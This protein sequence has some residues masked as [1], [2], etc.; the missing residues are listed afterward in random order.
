M[1][2]RQSI[3]AGTS[4]TG[5]TGPSGAT[6]AGG[7]AKSGAKRRGGATGVPR[8]S[9]AGAGAGRTQAVVWHYTHHDLAPVRAG[10]VGGGL[11]VIGRVVRA[12]A[13]TGGGPARGGPRRLQPPRHRVEPRRAWPVDAVL[14]QHD[15]A[16]G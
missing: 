2:I 9:G 6:G 4:I 1:T 7:A 3:V 13:C 15:R 14:Q 16:T 11:F 10:R 8:I 5:P 12:A